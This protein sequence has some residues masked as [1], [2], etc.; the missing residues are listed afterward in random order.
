MMATTKSEV[1][2]PRHSTALDVVQTEG[3]EGERSAGGEA[4]SNRDDRISS[5]AAAAAA[6][7]AA[8]EPTEGLST[9]TA[10]QQAL[11][12]LAL[13]SEKSSSV[14]GAS[15]P[16]PSKHQRKVRTFPCS[17]LPL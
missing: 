15:F 10:I 8:A 4:N 11:A 2:P 17:L 3:K 7:A 9:T 12:A 13:S 1:V 14:S 6:A 16:E 5:E